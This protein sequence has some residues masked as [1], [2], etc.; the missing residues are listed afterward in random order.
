MNNYDF[1]NG[2]SIFL[3]ILLRKKAK[4]TATTSGQNEPNYYANMVSGW[5]LW[6]GSARSID[7]R[8]FSICSYSIVW[9]QTSST[10]TWEV[11]KSTYSIY[12]N[13]CW[14]KDMM[15][16]QWNNFICQL[17]KSILFSS[18]LSS[19]HIR[20]KVERECVTWPKVSRSTICQSAH[21]T[22]N[23][24]CQPWCAISRCCDTFCCASAFKLC[25]AIRRSVHWHTR[26]CSWEN[27]LDWE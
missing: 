7:N 19:L 20:I 23:V 22:I 12:R 13:V 14:P 15:W 8:Q 21:S 5:H 27:C 1:L 26:L 16:V 9:R 4:Q 10:R 24:S 2:K 3:P 18:R 17:S 11:S 25:T 6:I